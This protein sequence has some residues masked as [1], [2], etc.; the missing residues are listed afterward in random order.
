MCT[1]SETDD[2]CGFEEVGTALQSQRSL[3]E[4]K[5]L[6]KKHPRLRRGEQKLMKKCA[7][8]PGRTTSQRRP[9][10]RSAEMVAGESQ[11]QA[12]DSATKLGCNA[13][14]MM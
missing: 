10:G 3:S 5:K 12:A 4:L 1:D 9:K 2:V 13:G 11:M 14:S 8:D 6:M 7:V